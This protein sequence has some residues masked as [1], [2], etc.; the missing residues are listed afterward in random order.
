MTNHEVME[1]LKSTWGE[2][3]KKPGLKNLA[4]ICYEVRRAY[5]SLLHNP[6]LIHPAFTDPAILDR[7]CPNKI[8]DH[9]ENS[10]VPEGDE[11]TPA[12]R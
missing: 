6:L 4:T 5:S 8:A 12:N 3:K 10:G 11:T 2:E 9:R 7:E 1:L